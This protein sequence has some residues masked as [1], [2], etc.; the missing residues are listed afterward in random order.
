MKGKDIRKFMHDNRIPVPKDDKFMSDLIRQI[1]LLPTPASFNG[2][3]EDSMRI[4]QA[5]RTVLRKRYRRQAL[6]ALVMNAVVFLGFV[7][8]MLSVEQTEYSPVCQFI[9][10]WS[11][12]LM[13]FLGVC[14]VAISL[15]YIKSDCI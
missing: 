5:I 14:S 10:K 8:I 1:D 12:A 11:Y 2:D 4:V 3:K 15:T 9:T 7:F 13:G 6:K